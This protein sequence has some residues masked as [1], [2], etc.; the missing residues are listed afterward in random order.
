VIAMITLAHVLPT[1]LLLC[2]VSFWLLLSALQ[3]LVGLAGFAV[4]TSSGDDTLFAILKRLQGFVRESFTGCRF[5]GVPR[6]ERMGSSV[7]GYVLVWLSLCWAQV[8][9][10][11]SRGF[12]CA[13]ATSLT[14]L[15]YASPIY[16]LAISYANGFGWNIYYRGVCRGRCYNGERVFAID[17]H[18]EKL[19]EKGS[20]GRWLPRSQ[21]RSVCWPHVHLCWLRLEFWPWSLEPPMPDDETLRGMRQERQEAKERRE[22]RKQQKASSR[23]LSAETLASL[24]ADALASVGGDDALVLQFEAGCS[25]DVVAAELLSAAEERLLK[26]G[27]TPPVSPAEKAGVEALPPDVAEDVRK[28]CRRKAGQLF[29]DVQKTRNQKAKASVSAES[30]H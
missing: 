10:E 12:V 5:S 9:A 3:L 6:Y 21:M 27:L 30:A 25:L 22:A 23:A 13:S 11:T 15:L 29:G 26:S 17:W 16:P 18:E 2:S 8:R 19:Q 24:M 14:A 28:A 4:A 7:W 20:D 1:S